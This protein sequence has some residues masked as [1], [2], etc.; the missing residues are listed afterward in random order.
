[1][2]L[3]FWSSLKKFEGGLVAIRK[4]NHEKVVAMGE[5]LAEAWGTEMGTSPE[6]CS[7]M[8][9]VALPN[10]LEVSSDQDAL[11]LRSRLRK[12]FS[13]EVPIYYRAPKTELHSIRG[14]SFKAY[15]RISHQI[16]N[17]LDEYLTF[18]AAILQIVAEDSNS[19]EHVY[20]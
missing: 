6:L 5:M 13:V 9:M 7:S 4:K 16:Y 10:C 3:L 8:A 15:A 14:P 1:M 11:K 12:E 17:T 20:S 18:K 2:C 19:K